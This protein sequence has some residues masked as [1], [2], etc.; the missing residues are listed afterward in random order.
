MN[1]FYGEEEGLSLIKGNQTIAVAVLGAF[2]GTT[3]Y[4]PK[5]VRVIGQYFH[6]NEE[7]NFIYEDIPMRSCSD[8]DWAR[9]HTPDKDS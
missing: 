6:L 1:S 2:D 9:F 7:G 3:K 5:Y 8:D 4:D